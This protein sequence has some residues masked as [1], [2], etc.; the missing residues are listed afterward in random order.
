MWRQLGNKGAVWSAVRKINLRRFAT[1]ARQILEF[2]ERRGSS[3]IWR[4]KCPGHF[5]KTAGNKARC[6]SGRSSYAEDRPRQSS[7]R[8]IA[9]RRV[10]LTRAGDVIFSRL[11]T[12]SLD[13][14]MS[15]MNVLRESE[16]RNEGTNWFKKA[17]DGRCT[18]RAVAV[19][20]VGLTCL[21]VWLDTEATTKLIHSKVARNLKV[22]SKILP[23]K[24][25]FGTAV[26]EGWRKTDIWHQIWS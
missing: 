20:Y 11:P 21:K 15:A 1:V 12:D 22:T 13:K 25:H 6:P 3:K 19:A 18:L 2:T 16:T 7:R 17:G 14:C 10:I 9:E 5:Q 4:R 8:G 24:S 26:D 23:H